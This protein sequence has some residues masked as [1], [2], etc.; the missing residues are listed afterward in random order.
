[1]IPSHRLAIALAASAALA[2]AQTP[3]ALHGPLSVQG[4]HVVDSTGTPVQLRGMS[5]FWSM[6]VGKYWNAKAVKWLADDWKISVVR[7]A[8]GAEG[9]GGWIEDSTGNFVRLDAVV[10][11]AIANGTYVIVDWHDHN[12][13]HHPDSAQAFFE[14]VARK[15]GD[16]PNVIY[17]VWNEPLDVSWGDTVKPYAERIIAAIRAIDPDNLIVVGTPNWCQDVDSA[18]ADP[19]EG[20]N[21]AYSLHFYAG[22]HRTNYRNRARKAV[23]AGLPLFVTEWGTSKASGTG[24]LDL[25]ESKK[26]LAFLDSNAISW[27]NWSIAD[28]DETSAALKPRA[29]FTG[30]WKVD[31]LT[32]SGAWVRARLRTDAG[33]PTEPPPPVVA[34]IDTLPV[35]GRVEAEKASLLSGIETEVTGDV[36]GAQDIGWIDDGDVA[37]WRVA[38]A[39]AGAYSLRA[40]VAS[41]ELGGIVT[42][43]SGTTVV[44]GFVVPGTGGWQVWTDVD[45]TITL[46]QGVQTLRFTFN[47]TGTQGLM[48]LNWFEFATVGGDAVTPRAARLQARRGWVAYASRASDWTLLLRTPE[49]RLLASSSGRGPTAELDARSLPAGVAVVDFRDG[50][51]RFRS[52]VLV[53]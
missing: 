16:R 42:I 34:K 31:T 46:P 44:G 14:R 8:V 36:D 47:G 40:R 22:T 29:S 15:Y 39:Q 1:L 23:Q 52:T 35:P 17:E 43:R 38:V 50:N 28:K 7:A 37:E 30:G 5:L 48:N 3:V 6:W 32:E 26:W 25:E 49:G 4:A 24:L 9:A 45:T 20:S 18:A 21:I 27:A 53:P 2:G 12:A 10:D 41:A 11:A 51:A 13:S 33:F 19:I